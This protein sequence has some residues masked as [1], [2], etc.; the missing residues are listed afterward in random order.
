MRVCERD[1]E[2]RER[3][4]VMYMGNTD[5]GQLLDLRVQ[6]QDPTHFSAFTSLPSPTFSFLFDHLAFELDYVKIGFFILQN[7]IVV[8]IF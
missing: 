2:G 7:N 1:K 5:I 4:C 6:S 3:E 8:L